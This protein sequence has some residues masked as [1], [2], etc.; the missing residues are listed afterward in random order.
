MTFLL[1]P[2]YHSLLSFFQRRMRHSSRKEWQGEGQ[3]VKQMMRKQEAGRTYHDK[4]FI[5]E[6][7]GA[8]TWVQF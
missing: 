1:S 4:M 2:L 6:K 3:R 5:I 8:V 7:V